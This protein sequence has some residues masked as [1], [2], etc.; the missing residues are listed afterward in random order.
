METSRW[1]KTGR[2]GRALRS[3]WANALKISLLPS[4][5]PYPWFPSSIPC[6]QQTGLFSVLRWVWSAG[7]RYLPCMFLYL[8][9]KKKAKKKKKQPKIPSFFVSLFDKK[10]NK[11]PYNSLPLKIQLCS[12]LR[13]TRGKKSLFSA[14]SPPANI[15]F[16]LFFHWRITA[17]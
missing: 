4:C 3:T 17:L 8:L 7:M 5:V 14:T 15:F 11:T 13:T 2:K 9:N 6:Q 10:T 12:Q 1:T 16:N